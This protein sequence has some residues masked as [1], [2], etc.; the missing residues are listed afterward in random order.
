MLFKLLAL[1]GLQV[2][3]IDAKDLIRGRAHRDADRRGKSVVDGKRQLLQQ[4]LF[5]LNVIS[6]GRDDALDA[7]QV[8]R[9]REGDGLMLGPG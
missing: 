5:R 3:R 8:E 2:G 1:R 4:F 6:A 9:R 7:W